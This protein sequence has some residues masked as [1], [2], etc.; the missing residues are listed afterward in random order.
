MCHLAANIYQ[1]CCHRGDV[2]VLSTCGTSQR[3]LGQTDSHDL[4]QIVSKAG[5]CPTCLA[6]KA[7]GYHIAPYRPRRV[8]DLLTL[9]TS[10]EEPQPGSPAPIASPR[11]ILEPSTPTSKPKILWPQ[12]KTAATYAGTKTPQRKPKIDSHRNHDMFLTP[13]A[14]SPHSYDYTPLDRFSGL[15]TPT[16]R[17]GPHTPSS[18]LYHHTPRRVNKRP[19]TPLSRGTFLSFESD[20]SPVL[21]KKRS[22]S[23]STSSSR[24]SSTLSSAR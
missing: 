20:G 24:S 7:E 8:G 3:C 14:S 15:K 23:S 13:R 22:T 19:R 21:R 10:P 16:K 6:K 11:K 17:L 5:F 18:T 12:S 1:S 4:E 2:A 9:P